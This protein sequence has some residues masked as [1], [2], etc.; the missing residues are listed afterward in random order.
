MTAYPVLMIGAR[1]TDAPI[2]PVLIGMILTAARATSVGILPVF[3]CNNNLKT[4][5]LNVRS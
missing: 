2:S 4:N 5:S 1:K 3:Q